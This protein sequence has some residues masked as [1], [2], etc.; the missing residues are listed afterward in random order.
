MGENGFKVDINALQQVGGAFSDGGRAVAYL[1]DRLL[2]A[3]TPNTGNAALDGLIARSVS[4]I[5]RAL[6]GAGQALEADASGLFCTANKP[7]AEALG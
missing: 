5:E 7:G 4:E 3:G 6:T 2:G 1:V